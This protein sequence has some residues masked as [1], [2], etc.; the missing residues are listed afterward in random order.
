MLECVRKRLIHLRK[1][2]NLSQ[3]QLAEIFATS[4]P[5]ICRFE[6]GNI[7]PSY[8]IIIKYMQFF[9]VTFDYLMCLTNDPHYALFY[10]QRKG[11]QIK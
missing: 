2:N 11:I 9:K 10:K 4:Q 8:D 3:V 7:D 1:S 5:N 6:R